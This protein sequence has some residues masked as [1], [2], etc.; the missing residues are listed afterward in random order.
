MAGDCALATIANVTERNT[1]AETIRRTAP[2][3]LQAVGDA[4][5]RCRTAQVAGTARLAGRCLQWANSR[6]YGYE[7]RNRSRPAVLEDRVEQHEIAEA[8]QTPLLG[9]IVGRHSLE[10]VELLPYRS[11]GAAVGH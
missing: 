10:A 8:G 2:P 6:R 7:R 11:D 4:R 3:K 5:A 1:A 9:R